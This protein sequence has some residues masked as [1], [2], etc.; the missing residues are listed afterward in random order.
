M[1]RTLISLEDEEKRWLDRRAKEEGVTMT[2]I[3]R[4]AVKRY[5]QECGSQKLSY[6][7]LLEQTAGLLSSG[8]DGLAVQGRLRSEWDGD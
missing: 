5:R 1:I 8:E 3:V 6:Q 4:K 7:R 2:E